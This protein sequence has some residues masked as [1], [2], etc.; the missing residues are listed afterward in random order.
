MKPTVACVLGRNES[1]S[2]VKRDDDRFESLSMLSIP[3]YNP[4]ESDLVAWPA[5][6]VRLDDTSCGGYE[7]MTHSSKIQSDDHFSTLAGIHSSR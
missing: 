5:R 2:K 3:K 6:L 7:S 1:H 4:G